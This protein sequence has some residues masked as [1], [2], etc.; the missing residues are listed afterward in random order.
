ML[1]A[2]TCV[3]CRLP[4]FSLEALAY[5]AH[6]HVQLRN[7]EGN[8]AFQLSLRRAVTKHRGHSIMGPFEV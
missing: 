4:L 2:C 8:H 1:R 6:G 3:L 7:L 5:L